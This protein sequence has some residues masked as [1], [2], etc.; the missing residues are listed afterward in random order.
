MKLNIISDEIKKFL[1]ESA[2]VKDGYVFVRS[3][4]MN[5]AKVSGATKSGTF[6]HHLK[7][8][9]YL[10]IVKEVFSNAELKYGIIYAT[11]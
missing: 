2:V 10:E 7:Q 9:E 5:P 4:Y 1:N 11:K 3:T 8:E 6:Q